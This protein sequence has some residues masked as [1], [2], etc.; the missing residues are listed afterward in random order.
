M[1]HEKCGLGMSLAYGFMSNL[2]CALPSGHDGECQSQYELDYRMKSS[3]AHVRTRSANEDSARE[4]RSRIARLES[5][6]AKAENDVEA[7]RETVRNMEGDLER[8]WAEGL[9]K[10]VTPPLSNQ[11]TVVVTE[12]T[13]DRES[14][15]RNMPPAVSEIVKTLREQTEV[16][17]SYDGLVVIHASSLSLLLDALEG[18]VSE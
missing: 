15:T 7:L 6:M 13:V 17:L 14:L 9:A 5:R 11:G 4:L 18:K 12:V 1:T 16:A 3:C 2:P 8:S 10:T